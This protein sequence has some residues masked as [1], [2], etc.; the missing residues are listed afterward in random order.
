MLSPI[1]ALPMQLE[2][3]PPPEQTQ[4]MLN[5]LSDVEFRRV[6]ERWIAVQSLMQREPSGGTAA[7]ST[8]T[9]SRSP[10]HT[11]LL[12]SY[13]SLHPWSHP[14]S[15]VLRSLFRFLSVP[16]LVLGAKG[17]CRQWKAT[18]GDR[19]EEW[20]TKQLL[21]WPE[22]RQVS[23]SD[24]LIALGTIPA[25]R[26]IRFEAQ[27]GL[28]F[29]NGLRH[30]A[31]MLPKLQTLEFDQCTS[32]RI[33]DFAVLLPPKIPS[34]SDAPVA[35]LQ[36][37]SLIRCFAVD[38]QLMDLLGALPHLRTLELESLQ[39][40]TASR[41][42]GLHWLSSSLIAQRTPSATMLPPPFPHLTSLSLSPLSSDACLTHIV[43]RTQLKVLKIRGCISNIGIE[44]LC[45]MQQLETLHVHCMYQLPPANS[46]ASVPAMSQEEMA[47]ICDGSGF[48]A[49]E[50]LSGLTELNASVAAL[51]P[52]GFTAICALKS[53][54]KLALH[55]RPLTPS[56]SPPTRFSNAFALSTAA[57]I[58][59][60]LHVL[61]NLTELD[62][63]GCQWITD[64][65]IS[66][67]THQRICATLRSLSLAGVSSITDISAYWLSKLTKLQWMDLR[68]TEITSTGYREFY[69]PL[70]A[71]IILRY[72][73]QPAVKRE[74]LRIPAAEKK[75]NSTE[76]SAAAPSEPVREFVN[77]G[78]QTEDEPVE[79]KPAAP[80]APVVVKVDAEVLTD[81]QA[82]LPTLL[83]LS[84][85]Q[86]PAA[87]FYMRGNLRT[88]AAQ[89]KDLETFTIEC[90]TD[91]AVKAAFEAR[92]DAAVLAGEIAGEERVREMD[93][94]RAEKEMARAQVLLSQL[95]DKMAQSQTQLTVMPSSVQESSAS[96]ALVA[97]NRAVPEEA[98][99]TASPME[100][101][102][103]S[104]EAAR[105]ASHTPSNRRA[106]EVDHA[107]SAP[108]NADNH[109]APLSINDLQE[110]AHA[111]RSKP[112]P[113]EDTRSSELAVDVPFSPTRPSI[114]TTPIVPPTVPTSPFLAHLTPKGHPSPPLRAKAT[115][116]LR[117]RAQHSPS[118][119]LPNGFP[120]VEADLV[121][122]PSVLN[123]DGHQQDR[124]AHGH[125]VLPPPAELKGSF[126]SSTFTPRGLITDV[127]RSDAVSSPVMHDDEV[128]DLLGQP[129]SLT[130]STGSAQAQ[131][132]TPIRLFQNG[133]P[134]F[135][136]DPASLVPTS[137]EELHTPVPLHR[138]KRTRTPKGAS[139]G[140]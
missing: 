1:L 127:E 65:Q 64:E 53:L 19:N 6:M 110:S 120:H 96:A 70:A 25:L 98:A 111:V 8:N 137:P 49:L 84:Q 15:L 22:A 16:D 41:A 32:L 118:A 116:P 102:A 50:Q 42:T 104:A 69:R 131:P 121:L 101:H 68:G 30:A 105:P 126:F 56:T 21:V 80:P 27:N 62:L 83:E 33:D 31:T 138:S 99:S 128:D 125:S 81:E 139:R 117:T 39:P 103:A 29:S 18:L 17:V 51:S 47:G 67:L 135:T 24:L 7:S 79:E 23:N 26:S 89:T 38:Q 28:A 3:S 123:S 134:P 48:A 12:E 46:S 87:A 124:A 85:S 4:A 43:P 40:M 93:H 86:S 60:Q 2:N 140:P 73:S 34:A 97:E 13:L 82:T 115:P 90:Q 132:T 119:S 129:L 75:E 14:P 130:A 11:S 88:V 55:T 5:T 114:P 20:S 91:D 108:R 136:F 107:G 100:S 63:S 44:S 36:V 35:A 71:C 52:A 95:S 76:A 106:I 78:V 58:L 37:L 92:I 94:A 113:E 72:P 77:A 133:Q 45:I 59:A 109:A 9:P 112:P 57:A 54:K 122:G 74:L 66:F 10:L 61:S